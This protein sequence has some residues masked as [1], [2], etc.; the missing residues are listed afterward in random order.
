[1]YQKH[2]AAALCQHDGYAI[3][4]YGSRTKEQ[5]F[6]PKQII[7]DFGLQIVFII[8]ILLLN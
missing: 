6:I 7:L 2:I 8:T 3:Y 5:I 4:R 1:M